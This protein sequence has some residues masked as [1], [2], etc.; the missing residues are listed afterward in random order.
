M[1]QWQTLWNKNVKSLE[2]NTLKTL[3]IILCY[4]CNRQTKSKLEDEN[5]SKHIFYVCLVSLSDEK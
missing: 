5:K 3:T 2:L 4:D 1:K